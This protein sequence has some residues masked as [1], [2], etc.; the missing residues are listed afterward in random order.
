M[1]QLSGLIDEDREPEL[2]NDPYYKRQQGALRGILADIPGG[3]VDVAALGLDY[4]AQGAESLLPKSASNLLGIPTFRKSMQKPFL[5]SAFIEEKLEDVGVLRPSTN[6]PEETMNRLAFGFLDGTPGAAG[7]TRRVAGNP[8]D[9]PGNL[10][11]SPLEKG[12]ADLPDKSPRTPGAWK[13]VLSKIKGREM[14]FIGVDDYLNALPQNEKIGIE[15]LEGFM[16]QNRLE[17]IERQKYLPNVAFPDEL[18]E[19]IASEAKMGAYYE[20]L[21]EE[22]ADWMRDNVEIDVD[23]YMMT[24]KSGAGVVFRVGDN[25]IG[26]DHSPSDMKEFAQDIDELAKTNPLPKMGPEMGPYT[27]ADVVD[28]VADYTGPYVNKQV[29]E[30]A[31]SYKTPHWAEKPGQFRYRGK[32]EIGEDQI[33]DETYRDMILYMPE[34]GKLS[35]VTGKDERV[36]YDPN[37]Q[38]PGSHYPEKNI[39]THQ[40]YSFRTLPNGERAML[41]EEIQSDW[42]KAGVTKGFRLYPDETAEFKQILEDEGLVFVPAGGQM[43]GPDGSTGYYATREELDRFEREMDMEGEFQTA[44]QMETQASNVSFFGE[45]ADENRAI[46]N[47]LDDIY[48]IEMDVDPQTGRL[49]FS[50]FDAENNQRFLLYDEANDHDQIN[51]YLE[52]FEYNPA[53]LASAENDI[54]NAIQRLQTNYQVQKA[55]VADTFEMYGIEPV[56]DFEGTFRIFGPGQEEVEFTESSIRNGELE[57]LFDQFGE[58]EDTEMMISNVQ[59]AVRKY[60]SAFDAPASQEPLQPISRFYEYLPEDYTIIQKDNGEYTIRFPGGQTDTMSWQ[61]EDDAIAQAIDMGAED[62][63]Q[64]NT[65]YETL[66]ADIVDMHESNPEEIDQIFGQGAYSKI[67]E[68]ADR[69]PLV[70]TNQLVNFSESPAVIGF[71]GAGSPNRILGWEHQ[72]RTATQDVIKNMKA[73]DE[74]TNMHLRAL[75]VLGIRPSGSMTTGLGGTF[76]DFEAIGSGE[77][78]PGG[79]SITFNFSE[80]MDAGS[81]RRRQLLEELVPIVRSNMTTDL[82]SEEIEV[83]LLQILNDLQQRNYKY[84]PEYIIRNAAGYQSQ[85]IP[86]VRK[87]FVEPI[88]AVDPGQM[89]KGAQKAAKAFARQGTTPKGP[90]VSDPNNPEW[91]NLAAKRLVQVATENDADRIMFVGAQGQTKRWDGLDYDK[92]DFI[93]D[94][95]FTSYLQKLE[96][97]FGEGNKVELGKIEFPSMDEF[98]RETRIVENFPNIKLSE[99]L[100]KTAREGLPYLAIPLAGAA[101][102]RERNG[103]ISE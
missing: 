87:K 94:K 17:I 96:N 22:L 40:R 8:G 38:G 66:A 35:F 83:P 98:N 88:K 63:A 68:L 44:D 18:G 47:A 103:L 51:S 101:A 84:G 11:Y 43:K 72:G 78:T 102:Q 90:F 89:S 5:G 65:L 75:E 85:K 7:I 30:I 46:T 42:N 28:L 95:K 21:P 71:D 97:Q 64:V 39:L 16:R 27:G 59:E 26:Y 82:P 23:P 20:T 58:G 92:A 57:L 2:R 41:V 37:F 19:Q 49:I 29:K 74:L 81:I 99:K 3:V 24:T 79:G 67:I 70:E 33:P 15:D 55:G 34:K 60:N 93:Y 100:K 77:P 62:D 73:D 13:N 4:L 52:P 91:I 25:D 1:S 86:E 56:V 31:E 54:R 69:S 45:F 6:T 14:P 48:N 36:E 9:S 50:A 61:N 12:L 76:P 32:T 10:L 80:L 53:Q